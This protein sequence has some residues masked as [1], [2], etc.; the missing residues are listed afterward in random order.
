M[1]LIAQRRRRGT[2]ESLCAVLESRC[3][4]AEAQKRMICGCGAVAGE[5]AVIS[6]LERQTQWRLHRCV[7]FVKQVARRL[8]IRRS[9]IHDAADSVFRPFT[10]DPDFAVAVAN[11]GEMEDVVQ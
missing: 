3:S 8:K 5:C 2:Q 4:S 11:D 7:G 1:P 10:R 6:R 9:Q